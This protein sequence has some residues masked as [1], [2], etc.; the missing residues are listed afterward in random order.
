MTSSACRIGISTVAVALIAAACSTKA[1]VTDSSTNTGTVTNN[2]PC[3]LTLSGGV[4]NSTNCFTGGGYVT[5][6]RVGS[7]S[8]NYTAPASSTSL[9]ST[10]VIV[11]FTGVP[12]AGIYNGASSGAAATG[13][14]SLGGNVWN[15]ALG[16]GYATAGSYS[17]SVT[18]VVQQD[19]NAGGADYFI[20]GT[21]TVTFPPL[22]SNTNK[23]PVALLAT[24]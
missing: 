2:V 13:S 14:V 8:L 10:L 7:F 4:A 6:T 22:S 16:L 1:L 23:T 24:F 15:V 18:S 11:Y 9:A 17:L 21:L 19:T 12:V 20:H 5:A 3:A